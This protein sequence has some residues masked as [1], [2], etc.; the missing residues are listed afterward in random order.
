MLRVQL[1]GNFD[2]AFFKEALALK[3][4]IRFIGT[5]TLAP[6]FG[7]RPIR[8]LR[9]RTPNTPNDQ[10]PGHPINVSCDLARDF[11]SFIVHRTFGNT[12]GNEI[13]LR[14]FFTR[15]EHSRV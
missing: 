14:G 1:T 8:A 13:A 5:S 10:R 9:E 4:A 2:T 15:E 6:V 7:F 3:N 12:L 11:Q